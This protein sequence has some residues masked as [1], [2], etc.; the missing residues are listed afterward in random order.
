[1]LRLRCGIKAKKL[2]S[3]S[4]Y[5]E[6]FNGAFTAWIAF[7]QQV[8]SFIVADLDVK[9]IKASKK[10]KNSVELARWTT[11]GLYSRVRFTAEVIPYQQHWK[12][13]TSAER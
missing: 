6:V 3:E 4:A 9:A 2:V 5:L 13:I 1:M 10:A 8:V 12:R 11:R 7:P